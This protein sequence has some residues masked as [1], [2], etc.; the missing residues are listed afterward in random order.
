MDLLQTAADFLPHLLSAP[1][2]PLAALAVSVLALS[3]LTAADTTVQARQEQRLKEES[4]EALMLTKMHAIGFGVMASLGLLAMWLWSNVLGETTKSCGKNYMG[5][6]LYADEESENKLTAVI[7]PFFL[8][9][10]VIAPYSWTTSLYEPVHVRA[11]IVREYPTVHAR[12]HAQVGSWTRA[13]LASL[14]RCGIDGCVMVLAKE[15]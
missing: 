14:Y 4:G 12:H 7:H 3:T 2:L 1:L 6:I 8:F 10:W 5:F 15:L 13:A 9:F 11:W